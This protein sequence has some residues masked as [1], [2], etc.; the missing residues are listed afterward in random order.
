MTQIDDKRTGE[1]MVV[2][3]AW[4]ILFKDDYIPTDEVAQ[5][6]IDYMGGLDGV[7]DAIRICS[8][9]PR[10]STK[11]FEHRLAYTYGIMRNKR[12][13]PL[14]KPWDYAK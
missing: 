5:E 8:E 14:C 2:Q 9:N 12:D 11:S 6:M 10:V 3:D 7:I 13:N 4:H 1:V